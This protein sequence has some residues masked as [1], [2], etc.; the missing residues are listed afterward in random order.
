MEEVGAFAGEVHRFVARRVVNPADAE[1]IAQQCLLKAC[2]SLQD[3]RGDNLRAWLLAIARHLIVDHYR[4]RGRFEF[5]ET[6]EAA[7]AETEPALRSPFDAVQEACSNRERLHCYLQCI[8]Q[9]LRLEEQLAV[10]LSDVHGYRDKDAATE[11]GLP[12]P[13]Y[14]L[15][16]HGARARLHEIAGGRCALVDNRTAIRSNGSP[17]QGGHGT[18]RQNGHN[19]KEVNG[20]RLQTTMAVSHLAGPIEPDDCSACPG[21]ASPSGHGTPVEAASGQTTAVATAVCIVR[22]NRCFL[23]SQR[24]SGGECFVGVHWGRALKCP[25]VVTR[26]LALR[27]T[28]LKALRGVAF[29]NGVGLLGAELS[30]GHAFWGS[31]ERIAL[32]ALAL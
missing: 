10:L 11:L 7:R 4:A 12:L 23:D 31:V 8:S 14:K 21:R 6:E 18:P 2:Q 13:T 32:A 20:H 17:A 5:V 24:C 16:L 29:L 1:D 15:L 3:F 25:R 28:L 27:N 30:H 19:G 26:F 9:R 22:D